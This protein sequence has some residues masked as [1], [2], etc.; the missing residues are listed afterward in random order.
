MKKSVLIELDKARNL[1]FGINALCQLEDMIGK[2]VTDLQDGAGITEIRAM[3]Y[4]GLAWEDPD[5]TVDEVGEIMDDAMSDKGI[6]YISKKLTESITLS[7]GNKKKETKTVTHPA[8]K[9]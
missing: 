3:L 9:K 6:D 2:P 7:I 5:L 8:I 4:C 1:R